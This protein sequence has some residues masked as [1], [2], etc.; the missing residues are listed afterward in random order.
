LTLCSEKLLP[1]EVKHQADHLN[2]EARKQRKR[3]ERA[4]QARDSEAAMKYICATIV[5][6]E[7]VHPLKVKL[8]RWAIAPPSVLQRWLWLRQPRCT[9]LHW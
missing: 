1:K 8:K 7:D 2:P 9:D 3:E 4:A 6:Y 5:W